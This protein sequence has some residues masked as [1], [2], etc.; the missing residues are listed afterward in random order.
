MEALKSTESALTEEEEE[1][2]GEGE[3]EEGEDEDKKFWSCWFCP[4]AQFM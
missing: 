4:S 2:E 1:K 3:G